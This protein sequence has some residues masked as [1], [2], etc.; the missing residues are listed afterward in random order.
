MRRGWVLLALALGVGSAW[1][2]AFEVRLLKGDERNGVWGTD[3][4]SV[5]IGALGNLNQLTVGGQEIAS[6]IALYTSPVPL[7]AAEGA[8]VRTVQGE[9]VGDRGLTCQ[10]PEMTGSEQDGRRRFEFH[11]LVANKQVKDGAPLCD[12]KQTVELTPTGEIEL[13]YDCEWLESIRWGGF[14]L[15]A[16]FK[17]ESCENREFL[18]HGPDLLKTGVLDPGPRGGDQRQIRFQQFEQVT[19]RTEPGPV[20]FVWRE[21]AE[22]A[23]H[24]GS[25]IGLAV[26]P[27]DPPRRLP[28][29]KG[30]KARLAYRILLP[31]SQQ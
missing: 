31:V 3:E 1:G 23:L 30:R 9:G 26:G 11:H 24:W 6:V 14:S 4:Y 29:L 12:V 19:I 17:K 28:M 16:Y 2:R 18:V 27:L 13:V 7:E 15:M 8:G 20:H 5:R 22:C 21:P 10:P 25:D